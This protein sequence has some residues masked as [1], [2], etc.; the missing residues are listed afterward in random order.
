MDAEQHR[1]KDIGLPHTQVALGYLQAPIRDGLHTPPADDMATTYQQPQYATYGNR[2]D[3]AY[4]VPGAASGNYIGGYRGNNNQGRP[5]PAPHSTMNYSSQPSASNLRNEVQNPQPSYRQPSSPQPPVRSSILAPPEEEPRRRNANGDMILPN[6]QIPAS[7]NNSGGSLAEFA[8]Q[9][10]CLFWFESTETLNKAES[11]APS[12]SP[13]KRLREEAI[14]SS[15]F[16]KWV[17]TILSTTQV[18]QN[19]IL[20]ALLFIYRLKKINPAVK[21]RS[22]S[23]YRLLTVA[24]MLGNKFLDDNTYT[25]KTWAE[26]SGISVNEIHVMEVEFLSNMRYSLLASKEQWQEWQEKLGKFWIYC[27]RAM[28]A[29]QT[30]SIPPPTLPSPP[31]SLQASPPSVTPSLASSYS[32]TASSPNHYTQPWLMNPYAAPVSST[33]IPAHELRSS[34]RK[35]SY[36]GDVEEPTAKRVTRPAATGPGTFPSNAPSMRPDVPRLPVPNLT[37]S[38]SQAMNHAY[39]GATSMSQ[40][41]PLLPPINGRAM[42]TVYPTTPSWTPN[43]PVLTPTG[44]PSQHGP[45]NTNSYST[46]SRRQSPHSVHDLLSLGSS[47]I[48]AHFPGQNPG[49]ISPSFFLQQRNSP[50][51]PVRRVNTLLF[52]PPSHGFSSNVDQM[53]YQPLGRRND[54]RTGVV[55]EYTSHGPY[56]QWPVLP[57][58]NFHA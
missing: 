41:V 25:N 15:G 42:S 39:N 38:T 11:L 27:D 5:Y 57:Q 32:A 28:K 13:I 53:H 47:P 26:V 40:N 48:S 50:Y 9:I 7:I 43:L 30:L 54:Y 46:P 33:A 31:G 35:R 16:R 12:S 17:V 18:T 51:K 58:P 56:E 34:T 49:H 37:I 3:S 24:L 2:Q 29:S 52:P 44:P 6:L 8:A 10:T 19:V 36:D 20:L 55:P 4:S 21:G 23:E 1:R 14:P 45:P 22:G